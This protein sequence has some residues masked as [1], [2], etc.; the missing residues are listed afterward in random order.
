MIIHTMPVGPMQ[1]CCYVAA[2]ERTRETVI[3]DPG[4][5]PERIISVVERGNLEPILVLDTHGHADH[6]AANAQMKARFPGAPL[7]VHE[8]DA[9]MLRDPHA[10]LSALFGAPIESPPPDRTVSDGDVLRVGEEE[11]KVIHIGGHSPGSICL[12]ALADE[13]A[14]GVLFS[15]DVLFAGGIGRTDFAG[16]NH[17]ELIDGIREKLLSLPEETLVY[18]GHGPETTLG[19]EARS[20]PFL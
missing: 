17:Q 12:F 16:G 18:P 5:E 7:V 11:F 20:N 9:A 15:G 2:C 1:A 14:K 3:I 6:I 4:G 19:E 8:F 10:N 13:N